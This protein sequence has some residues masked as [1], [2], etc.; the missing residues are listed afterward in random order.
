MFTTRLSIDN[1]VF[2]N[3]VAAVIMAL[4]I[5]LVVTTMNREIFPEFSLDMISV[6]TVFQGASPEEM[7]KL[8]TI[9]LEN[10]IDNVDGIDSIESESSEGISVITLKLQ[11]EVDDVNRVINDIQTAI[12]NIRNELP[13]E[14]EDPVVTEL[15]NRFPVIVLSIYGEVSLFTLKNIAD[16]VEE[17]V[18]RLP[19]VSRVRVVGIGDREV[20][21]E[22]DPSAL[23][24]YGLSI[25]DIER[26]LEAK[27]LNLPGGTLKTARGEYLVRTVGEV[28]RAEDLEQVVVRATPEGNLLTLGQVASVRDTFEEPT[29]LGRFNGRRAI[30]IQV[31]KEKSGDTISIANAVRQFARDYEERLPPG[32]RLGVFNDFSVY[33]RNRLNTLKQ[34][35]FIGLILVLFVLRLFLSTRVAILTA[36]GIPV[37]FC[38]ALV[39]MYFYGISVNMLSAFSLIIVLGMVVDDAIVVTE[40]IYRHME[41]GYDPKEAAR[42]GTNQVFMPVVAST[43]TTIA[44]FIPMLMMPG[45]MGKFMSVIPLVV[46]FALLASLFEALVVLPSHMAE[47]VRLKPSGNPTRDPSRHWFQR[48]VAVYAR[49]LESIL[50]WRY[51][52]ITAVLCFSVLL[53]LFAKY[54]IPFTL[55]SRF[56][57]DQFFI[58]IEAPVTYK[59]EDT[60]EVVRSV[61]AIVRKLP[62]DELSTMVTNVGMTLIDVNEL[63]TGS[64]LAQIIVE[65]KKMPPRRRNSDEVINALRDKVELVPGIRKVQFLSPQAGPGGPAIEINVEGEDLT[66]LSAIAKK[67]E[68]YMATLPGV[69]DIRDTFELGKPEI[70]IFAKPEAMALG[71]TV[72]EIARQVRDRFHGAESSKIQRSKEDIQILVKYPEEHRRHRLDVERIKLDTPG[73]HKV[74]FSEVA[75]IVEKRGFT[76]ISR[77][78]MKRAVTVLADVDKTKANALEVAGF[79]AER[80]SDLSE[81][82]PGYRLRFKG[83]QKDVEESVVSLVKAFVVAVLLIYFILGSAFRSFIQPLIIMCAIP[84]A[85]DGVIVGHI[86]MGMNLTLL[87][88]IGTVALVGIVVN[89]SLVLVDFINNLRRQGLE[90][91]EAIVEGGKLRIR[92][93]CLTS[94]TTIAGLSPLAFFASGQARFLSPM[95]LSITWG[96]AFSTILILLLIPCFYA[97]VDDLKR[98]TQWLVGPGPARGAPARDG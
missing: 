93:I 71:L 76:Q 35:G 9:K 65:L 95:A 54:R 30:N 70:R 5:G 69:R 47:F 8:I 74:A 3:L 75:Y 14:A 13:E 77:S 28:T 81:R 36:L 44:A 23:E 46:S 37:A 86:A 12:D 22:V 82:Y 61:E 80:F 56:E 89:D 41:E 91:T 26:A 97:A 48:V 59:L 21:V 6:T 50:R 27:N 73:G 57:S 90:L 45:T 84:F 16:E 2:V 17:E 20:W 92:A 53:M 40:N 15:K 64:H 34:S 31:S 88:L 4:G 38:G 1:P 52:F 10:E 67:I 78:E 83:E 63:R 25:G 79:V 62:P 68:D 55:F 51:V 43:L 18:K 94:V 96:L 32:V 39:M 98:A 85:V 60:S 7:E 42:V 19:G 33:I 24:R 58:N 66:I 87:S 49:L 72:R 11:S 29:T